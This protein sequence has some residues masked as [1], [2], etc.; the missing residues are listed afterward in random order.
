MVTEENS[1]TM[2]TTIETFNNKDFG[3]LRSMMINNEPWFVGKDVADI[4]GYSNSRKAIADHVD[5]E[6]KGVTKC[7]TLGGIQDLVVINESGLYSLILSSKL[8][9]AKKFKHWVTSEVLPSIRKKGY[10]VDRDHVL[11][12][13]N[14]I[15]DPSTPLSREELAL[16]FTYFVNGAKDFITSIDKRLDA[17]E[18]GFEVI[19]NVLTSSAEQSTKLENALCNALRT[20]IS[21]VNNRN[22][23]TTNTVT[24]T[25]VTSSPEV[26]AWLR[27][28]WKSAA[29]ISKKAN[30]D[31]RVVLREIYKIL[32]KDGVDLDSMYTEY[33]E[34][35][36]GK[37]K[38]N[39]IAESKMLRGKTEEII[40]SLHKK[41]YPE[42]YTVE[43]IVSPKP[44]YK[45]QELLST[46]ENVRSY[47]QAVADREGIVYTTAASKV[48][49]EIE[50]RC[51]ENLKELS[52]ELARSYGCSNC[53]K[54][55]LIA[56][57]ETLMV[58]IKAI[59]EGK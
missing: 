23:V 14:T 36:P 58:I 28:V 24:T 54:A 10:A 37:A 34:S 29:I 7:D 50:K 27:K 38:I 59:A 12:S 1:K 57:D 4:L 32:R 40:K 15:T 45:S 5:E 16:Y 8:P 6:D 11:H 17:M 30:G 53:S 13:G 43:N 51:G 44:I 2:N 31:S 35:H 18:R 25:N 47:I 33:S 49:K 26:N 39:M 56:H 20:P 3:P 19:T 42:K 41:Y 48:Y 22:A 46:P 21:V 9:A 55:Y 52:K